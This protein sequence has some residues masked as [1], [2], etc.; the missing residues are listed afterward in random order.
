[1]D[2][3]GCDPV[4]LLYSFVLA[5]IIPIV[6]IAFFLRRS[7]SLKPSVVYY[8]SVTII[9]LFCGIIRGVPVTRKEGSSKKRDNRRHSTTAQTTMDR[10]TA[11]ARAPDPIDGE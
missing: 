4:L 9:P 7:F 6:G 1:M 8:P 2:D 5:C 11:A 10:A 3:S